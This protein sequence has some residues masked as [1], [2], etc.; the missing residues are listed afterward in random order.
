M[1][2]EKNK[3]KNLVTVII[4]VY[5]RAEYLCE[6]IESV[7]D[8]TY[9][10]YELII[11]DDGS[12]IDIKKI[13][14]PHL[15]NKAIKIKYLRQENKGLPAARNAGVKNSSGDFITFL[16]DDDLFEPKKIEV[17]KRIF[18]KFPS[19]GLVYS[20]YFRFYD[21]NYKEQELSLASGRDVNSD[22]FS[23][24]L[25]FNPNIAVCSVM[26][27][28]KCLENVGLFD[29]ALGYHDDGDMFL[30]IGLKW[31]IKFSNYPSAK[32]RFHNSKISLNRIKIYESEIK[33]GIKIL[34]QNPKFKKSLGKKADERMA[35]LY[36]CLG[37]EFFYKLNFKKAI[38]NFHLSRELSNKFVNASNLGVIFA[39]Y[40]RR[41]IKI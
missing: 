30:R 15:K 5:N 10:N 32:V 21:H 16:D 23:K 25:F 6:A 37:E 27:R 18:D 20:D 34:S 11:V 8:Q 35:E 12:K 2:Q 26:I 28:R 17:Q 36:Y 33:S 19:V 31:K 7:L 14:R 38:E 39:K 41:K 1:L 29:E 3:M 24:S 40:I 22:N 9:K 4:P 13:L